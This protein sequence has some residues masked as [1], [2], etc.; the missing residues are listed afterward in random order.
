MNLDIYKALKPII[1]R[2]K[3]RKYADGE[4]LYLTSYPRGLRYTATDGYC[5]VSVWDRD[6]REEGVWAIAPDQLALWSKSSGLVEPLR[7]TGTDVPMDVARTREAVL[8]EHDQGVTPPEHL[9]F[10]AQV[11]AAALGVF[12]ALARAAGSRPMLL[13]VTMSMTDALRPVRIRGFVQGRLDLDIEVLVAPYSMGPDRN[14]DGWRA[15]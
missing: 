12:G 8:A 10:D 3:A 14:P 9:S 13:P 2:A 1:A 11:M 4:W 7:V 6:D 15:E 5:M